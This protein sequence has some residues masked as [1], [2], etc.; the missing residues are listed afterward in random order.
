MSHPALTRRESS[1]ERRHAIAGA[2]RA[3]IIEKG[4]EGLR[5]RDIADRVGINIATLHYHVPTKDALIALVAESIRKDFQ[6]QSARRPRAGLSPRRQWQMELEDFRETVADMPD[7]I[8]LIVE[9]AQRARRDAAV[10]RVMRP[11]HDYW[12]S[13]FEDIIRRGMADGTFRPDIDALAAASIV[14]GALSDFWR[15]DTRDPDILDRI[16]R[17]MERAFLLPLAFK[18]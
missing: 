4:F 8:A 11:L 14:T 9:L 16:A 7:L 17:E 10:D 15:R 13:Q 12:R 3:I 6:A 2:A 5:T 18:D 1:D